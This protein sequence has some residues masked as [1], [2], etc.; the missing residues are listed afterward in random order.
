MSGKSIIRFLSVCSDVL[1][2]DKNT[3]SQG[4]GS[5]GPASITYEEFGR[6][7]ARRA[8][9]FLKAAFYLSGKR[10]QSGILTRP[11][12]GALL[13]QS[14]QIEE[15]LDAYGARTNSQW[16]R[17]RSIT[18]TIK[19][20]ANVGYEILHIQHAQSAY[21]L[22]PVQ[23]NFQQCT[24][25]TLEFITEI[26]CSA[27]DYLLEEAANL[28]LPLGDLNEENAHYR[29][30]FPAGRLPDDQATSKL[31]TV[32]QTVTMLSTAFLN[33]AAECR[34]A[35]P[36]EDTRPQSYLCE[37]TGPVSEEKLRSLELRFHNLQSLYDTYVSTTE[38]EGFDR[39]IPVMR[40]HISVVL[41]LLRTARDF[42]HYYE[43]HAGPTAL[44]SS[45]SRVLVDP[46]QLLA[47]LINYSINFVREYLTC[48]EMLCQ[49]M[50]KRYAEIGRIT[51]AVPS[52]RGFHVRPATLVSKLALHYGSDI[53]ME[54]AGDSYDARSPLDMF[55]ANEKINAHKR[56]T[57]VS[58]IVRLNMVPE[59]R[60][61]RD[62]RSIMLGV[63]LTL[64]ERGKI[65]IYEQPLQI[66]EKPIQSG[67]KMLEQVSD[68]IVRLLITGKIDAATDTMVTFCGDKRVLEDIKLLAENGYG[69]D[70]FGNNT[71]LPDSL[72]YLR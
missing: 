69:E 22:L 26:L 61:D 7:L 44:Y 49:N 72:K 25:Q 43:R 63:I 60:T 70:N 20:F 33:L 58:E 6:F 11:L 29:E 12:L 9:V 16:A 21:R 32:S 8:E 34:Q 42:A 67:L 13:S 64:A 40:G 30:T 55:R 62:L 56:K 5:P 24:N 4:A 17:F 37:M 1:M 27:T 35:L 41:H 19:L 14:T 48:A 53:R 52:Y 50:L 10:G 36:K 39:D 47:V 57:L 38:A 59:E 31:E 68:E 51:V 23:H 18:A 65:I 66:E 54:L 2:N 3:E 15:L 28:N 45:G 46:E 71:P